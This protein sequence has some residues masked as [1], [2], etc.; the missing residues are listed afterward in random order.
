MAE[1]WRQGTSWVYFYFCF[2]PL[3]HCFPSLYETIPWFMGNVCSR[4]SLGPDHL[5]ITNLV[6]EFSIPHRD[7]SDPSQDQGEAPPAVRDSWESQ[8]TLDRR[9]SSPGAIPARRTRVLSQGHQ[10]PSPSLTN[11]GFPNLPILACSITALSWT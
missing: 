4:E 3:F 10:H 1:F 11:P 7:L 8:T 6:P 2:L 5:F 9:S